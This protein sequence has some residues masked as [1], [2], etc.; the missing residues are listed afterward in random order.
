MDRREF[1]VCSALGASALASTLPEGARAASA[2]GGPTD[3]ATLPILSWDAGSGPDRAFWSQKLHLPWVHP[4]AGDWLDARQQP[5]G[6]QS[7]A[8]LSA[9]VGGLDFNVTALV[10]RWLRGADNQGF[11]LR[12]A[13]NFPITLGG[14]NH[15]M[16]SAQPLLRIDTDA[17]SLDLP[18]LCNA[19]W[20]PSSYGGRDSRETFL[21]AAHQWFAALHFD[22]TGL[23]LPLRRATLHLSC[24]ALTNPAR[25]EVMELNAPRFRV[26]A[27]GQPARAG[28]AQG[29]VFDQGIASH[30]AV[31]FASDFADLSRARWQVGSPKQGSR[32]VRDPRSGSTVLHGQIAAGQLLGCDMQHNVIA[33]KPDGTPERV[34]NELHAR[35]YVML[36]GDWG[37]EVDANKMPGWDARMG[38]WNP[39]GYWQSTTG[40]GGVPTTGLKVRNT[41]RERWEYEGASM[42]G[43]GGMRSNDGNPYDHLFWLGSYIEHLDQGS[44]Y[45]EALPWPGVVIDKGRWHCIEQRIRMNTITGPLDALG[46]GTAAHDGQYTVWMDGVLAFSRVDLAWRRH[47][48]MG[49]QGFWLNWYH[50]GMRP[51]SHDMHFRMDSVVI[52][53]SYIGP[54]GEG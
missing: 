44:V 54:R 51:P 14:R 19:M 6:P 27:G 36:E 45:G 42:R 8:A 26:G 31:L 53:R 11:Y 12:S 40:N 21:L 48:E 37:S 22:L 50:G 4:G 34:E 13:E 35:Y 7:Y 1:V 49:I 17:G 23:K 20:T 47:P 52:A 16:A 18:C 15:A 30:P 41:K 3:A 2:S 39:V 10:Q 9:G 32:Q 43:F 5:Q 38:W 46:N 24:L 29:F 25:L 28:L 33:A